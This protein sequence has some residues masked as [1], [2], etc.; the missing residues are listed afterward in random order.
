MTTALKIPDLHDK[1]VLV[2]GASS[3]IG[4]AVAIAFGHQGAHVAVHGHR[5]VEGAGQVASDVRKAGGTAVVI[6][7]DLGKPGGG[8][9]VVHEAASQLGGLDVLVN[10]A[11]TSF[12]RRKLEDLP[13]GAYDEMLDLNFRSVF[14]ATRA[15]I[16]F[17][18]KAGGGAVIS[19]T[20]IAARNGGGPGFGLYAAAKAAVS[21]ITRSFAKELAADG[22]RV[23]AVAPGIIW[24][25]IHEDHTPAEMMPGI[26]AA[27]PLGR[28]GTV[29]ECVGTY[30]FLASTTLAGFVTGQIIEVNGGQLMP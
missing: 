4:A 23:N 18:R 3:G 7:G 9:R 15:A 30:L 13:D 2:T 8:A 11:G 6:P 28:V 25:R 12:A 10:N 22:I 24:T 21:N 1:R 29:E 20:S 17:L 19:T 16:P 26:L 5:G 14:E 27:I